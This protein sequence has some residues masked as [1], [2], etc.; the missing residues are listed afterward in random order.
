MDKLV[1]IVVPVYNAG[2]YIEETIEM[3]RRSRPIQIGSCC[4]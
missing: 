1:S 3:V 2:A 4:W